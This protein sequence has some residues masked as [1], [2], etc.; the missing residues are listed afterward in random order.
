MKILIALLALTAGLMSFTGCNNQQLAQPGPY[1]GDTFL[2]NADQT[3]STTFKTLEVFVKWEYSNRAL[4][5]EYPEVKKAADKIRSNYSLWKSSSFALRDA[6][7]ANPSSDN[8]TKLTT[9]L[10]VL[11]A[12]LSEAQSYI[13]KIATPPTP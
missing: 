11:T 10:S 5:V 2:F 12:A 7:A 1:N 13:V 6:Y 3:I 4:L 8:R 9:Q